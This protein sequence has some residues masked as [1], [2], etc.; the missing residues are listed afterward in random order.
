MVVNDD[1]E[2]KRLPDKSVEVTILVPDVRV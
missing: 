2:V 1:A